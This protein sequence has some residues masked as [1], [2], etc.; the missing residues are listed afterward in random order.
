MP[1]STAPRRFAAAIALALLALPAPAPAEEQTP[2][3]LARRAVDAAT[4]AG[5]AAAR[6]ALA[7]M[8]AMD[9]WEANLLSAAAERAAEEAHR[10]AGNA[11]EAQKA[12]LR[13]SEYAY[14]A[15]AYGGARRRIAHFADVADCYADA[16]ERG[17]SG[18]PECAR[19]DLEFDLDTPP[20]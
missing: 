5:D 14:D 20:G 11:H 16:A 19:L 13:F 17:E 7:R 2:R 8:D 12:A 1:L 4:R 3:E 10:I 6:H 15:V 9:D 18:Y